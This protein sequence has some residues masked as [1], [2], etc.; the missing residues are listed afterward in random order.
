[1]LSVVGEGH[2]R[3]NGVR[4]FKWDSE[5]MLGETKDAGEWKCCVGL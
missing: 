2:G 3:N 4:L 5:T 1:L